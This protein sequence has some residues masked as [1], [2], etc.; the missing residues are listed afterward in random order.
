MAL[1]RESSILTRV[2]Q[3]AHWKMN[4]A[5]KGEKVMEGRGENPAIHSQSLEVMATARSCRASSIISVY[6]TYES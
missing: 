4:D 3:S 1:K 5:S 6:Q 2:K